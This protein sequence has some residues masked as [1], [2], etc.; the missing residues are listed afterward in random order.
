MEF[1]FYDRKFTVQ[2]K[3]CEIL[4]T[5]MIKS[6]FL[7]K[8]NSIHNSMYGVYIYSDINKKLRVPF[9]HAYYVSRWKVFGEN[10]SMFG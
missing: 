10:S 6:W 7:N 4:P 3:V 8:P 2:P 9:I 5:K 1:F